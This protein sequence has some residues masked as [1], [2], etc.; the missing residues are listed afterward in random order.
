MGISPARGIPLSVKFPP[1]HADTFFERG[2]HR[3]GDDRWQGVRGFGRLSPSCLL[4]FWLPQPVTTR[5]RPST[6]GGVG[7]CIG[8]HSMHRTEGGTAGAGT[9]NST[10]FTASDPG[11]TCLKCHL[12][13]GEIRPDSH[14]VATA[15]EDMPS[16]VPPAQL[17][18]GGDFGWVKKS[19]R[20][21][22]G[23]GDGCG[24]SLG[25]RHGHNIV[26]IDYRFAPDTG[27]ITA[28]GG[29]FPAAR[30]SCISCHDPHGK[31]RR[32]AD[33]S[34]GKT[35]IPIGHRGRTAPARTRRGTGP[36]GFTVFSGRKDTH[37]PCMMER[38]SPR[39]R[40]PRCHRKITTCRKT[41][42]TR[43]WRTEKGCPN[44]AP[45]AIPH[46]SEEP[47]GGMHTPPETTSNSARPSPPITIGTS[48]PGI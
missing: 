4:S 28:P 46:S 44:G 3:L 7:D 33:G 40:P 25:E 27:R 13:V 37:L 42:A 29:S 36:W 9:D 11:S 18:P 21:G 43:R 31:Y 15:A 41:A 35:G 23:G 8:C 32:F 47:G 1:Q 14:L 26:A 17:S 16:G 6:R 48:H 20:W 38:P 30:L 2:F 19:F 24:S 45:I 22:T 5:R 12:K 10:S 34:I 39:T